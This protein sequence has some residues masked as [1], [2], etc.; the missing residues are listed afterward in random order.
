[1]VTDSGQIVVREQ[2]D[3][4][5]KEGSSL[6]RFHISVANI[7]HSHGGHL[8]TG[9]KSD[10]CTLCSFRN[11]CVSHKTWWEAC[12]QTQNNNLWMLSSDTKQ[13]NLSGLFPG[14]IK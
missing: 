10:L 12:I 4:P 3:H 7:L 11:H 2:W 1:M 6:F 8:G 5:Y 9:I 13:F 14:L